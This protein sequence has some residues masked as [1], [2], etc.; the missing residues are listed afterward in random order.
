MRNLT[1]LP[2]YDAAPIIN[3]VQDYIEVQMVVEAIDLK[4]F[5]FLTTYQNAAEVAEGTGYHAR[6]VELLCNALTAAGYLEKSGD[7]FKNTDV[8]SFYLDSSSDYYLGS[9]VQFWTQEK[10]TSGVAE[11]VRKGPLARKTKQESGKNSNDFR[12]MAVTSAQEMYTGRLQDFLH[13][14]D[15]VFGKETPLNVLDLGGGSGVMSIE[16]SKQFPKATIRVFDQPQVVAFTDQLIEAH[17]VASHVKTVGGNFITDDLGTGYDL[18]IASVIFDFVGD[19]ERMAQRIYDALTE[20]GVLYL[21]THNVNEN[22]TSPR[23]PLVGWLNKHVEGIDIL[24]TDHDIHAAIE[25]AGFTKTKVD[26][27][28]SAPYYLFRKKR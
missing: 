11:R 17:G 3:I 19:M 25:A 16:F 22:Y 18:V 15:G 23:K 26:G 27:L 6:N 5:D 13:I 20:D 8:V 4:L 2:P 28:S 12:Q 1:E 10:D 9:Y 7:T 24:K 21:T 14:V